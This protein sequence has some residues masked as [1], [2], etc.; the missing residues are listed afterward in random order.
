MTLFVSKFFKFVFLFVNSSSVL[1]GEGPGGGWPGGP[2]WRGV[3][4]SLR[5]DVVHQFC[6]LMYLS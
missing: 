3:L 1:G 6:A 5:L 2:L 4:N